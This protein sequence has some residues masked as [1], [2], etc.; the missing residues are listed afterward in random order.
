MELSPSLGQ[1][2]LLTEIAKELDSQSGFVIPPHNEVEM[3]Y[4]NEA[5]PTKPTFM[6][7]RLNGTAVFWLALS[8][9]QGGNLTR[10]QPD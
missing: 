9:D 7:F 1:N 8:Y 5:H 2:V 10:I 3:Q 6:T 4:N